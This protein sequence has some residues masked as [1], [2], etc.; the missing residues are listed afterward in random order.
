M[1]RNSQRRKKNRRPTHKEFL[2]LMQKAYENDLQRDSIELEN[3]KTLQKTYR[4]DFL[5]SKIELNRLKSHSK[6]MKQIHERNSHKNY[7]L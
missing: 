5:I 3:L 4:T 1:N 7:I 6:F 2:S